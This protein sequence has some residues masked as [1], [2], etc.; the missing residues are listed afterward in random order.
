M[1]GAASAAE[2]SS[3]WREGAS[4]CERPAT[5]ARKTSLSISLVARGRASGVSLRTRG[6]RILR[7]DD[8]ML[9]RGVRWS[10]VVSALSLTVAGCG[11][12]AKG[13]PPLTDG[14]GGRYGYAGDSVAAPSAAKEAGQA[15]AAPEERPGLGTQ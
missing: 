4:P 10:L 6:R 7:E 2:R 8:M 5:L 13:P 1:P 12:S 15:T 9:T 11:A 14:S 3:L